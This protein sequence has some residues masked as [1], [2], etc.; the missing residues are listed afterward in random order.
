[1]KE[2][3]EGAGWTLHTLIQVSQLLVPT[4]KLNRLMGSLFFRYLAYKGNTSSNQQLTRSSSSTLV[5]PF[6]HC[7]C[8]L[9]ISANPSSIEIAFEYPNSILGEWSEYHVQVSNK[10]N[11]TLPCFGIIYCWRFTIQTCSRF[12]DYTK[13]TKE[14]GK[15]IGKNPAWEKYY[16]LRSYWIEISYNSRDLLHAFSSI[17]TWNHENQHSLH[18]SESMLRH[19]SPSEPQHISQL[20]R[21]K[22][23][24][25]WV[26]EK[27]VRWSRG[28]KYRTH[29]VRH[30]DDAKKIMSTTNPFPPTNTNGFTHLGKNGIVTHTPDKP[31][32]QQDHSSE[33]WWADK[34][35]R[36][37]QGNSV[38]CVRCERGSDAC[39]LSLQERMAFS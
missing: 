23:V 31:R 18:Q 21:A 7:A 3:A 37:G 34:Q 17:D 10:V 27:V 26:M 39:P 11:W 22:I 14:P 36:K 32:S 1:M 16:D 20:P 8:S 15:R 38:P 19:S 25:S 6:H 5:H 33:K 2:V 4:R 28:G 9:S 24:Q 30:M 29:N 13:K 12:G 35:R